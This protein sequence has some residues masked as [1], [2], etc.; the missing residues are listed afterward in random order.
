MLKNITIEKNEAAQWGVYFLAF[1]MGTGFLKLEIGAVVVVAANWW[2]SYLAQAFD[3]A[4]NPWIFFAG[5]VLGAFLWFY[6]W[7]YLP[8]KPQM[9][10]FETHYF[11]MILAWSLMAFLLPLSSRSARSLIY[12][13]WFTALGAFAYAFATV[14]A[15]VLL[16]PPPH[17]SQ[18]V[19]I[20]NLFRGVLT[21]GNS[22]GISNLLCL[23][24]ITFSAGMLLD[25]DNRPMGLAWIG[26]LFSIAALWGAIELQQRTFFL[27]VLAVQPVIIGLL[28]MV[29]KRYR[30]G[31]LVF[32]ICL[33]YPLLLLLESFSGLQLL[34]RKLDANLLADARIEMLQFWVMHVWADPWVRVAV[35]PAPWDS[36][37]WFHNFFADVHR[38]SGLKAVLAACAF[39]GLLFIRTSCLLWRRPAWG[40][41][42]LAVALP[43][44][45]IMNTSVVPEGERQPFLLLIMLYTICECLLWQARHKSP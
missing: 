42:L 26:V 8:Y 2:K 15:T 40:A 37:Y 21:I 44:F 29:L 16:L 36:V 9:Y 33:A 6:W 5:C 3:S 19:E 11:K 4:K 10:P 14:V 35:G 30:E 20:R 23:I 17:Y 32:L 43:I 34:P 12:L 27:V 25:K 1:L 7:D 41:F 39:F 45:M 28:L 38:L 24:P 31:S 13:V 18:V 22:P